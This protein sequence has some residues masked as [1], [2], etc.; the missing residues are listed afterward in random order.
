MGPPSQTPISRV[1]LDEN[2]RTYVVEGPPTTVVR[3]SAIPVGDSTMLAVARPRGT[4]SYYEPIHVA[5]RVSDGSYASHSYVAPS[6][7]SPPVP[8][9]LI[10]NHPDENGFRG[11]RQREYSAR[12]AEVIV[13]REPYLYS[14][15]RG[16]REQYQEVVMPRNYV[17]RVPSVRPNEVPYQLSP[18][19]EHG[20][21]MS[22]GYPENINRGY[23]P[24][25][26]YEPLTPSVRDYS[27]RPEDNRRGYIPVQYVPEPA[28]RRYVD[29]IR[30]IERPREASQA[31]P[32]ETFR[33]ASYRY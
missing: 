4:E 1:P 2:Y 31:M 7:S 23:V 33:R 13:P 32:G 27:V 5:A 12:P 30:Y 6:R 21:R 18:Q 9:R 8:P 14:R 3:Q 24:P 20:S 28:G 26:R 10:V 17:Q 22:S 11:Y 16:P 19:E 25:G 15:E 29:E